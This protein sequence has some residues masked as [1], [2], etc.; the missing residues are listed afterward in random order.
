MVTTPTTYAQRKIYNEIFCFVRFTNN[1]GN[2]AT[3]TKMQILTNSPNGTSTASASVAETVVTAKQWWCSSGRSNRAAFG[4]PAKF[5]YPYSIA[6]AGSENAA[7]GSD[8]RTDLMLMNCR[9]TT[10]ECGGSAMIATIAKIGD[11]GT[12]RTIKNTMTSA[13]KCTWIHQSELGAPTFATE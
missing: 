9:Q 13:M 7:M 12:S 3:P 4:T 11:A 5:I 8:P 1:I 6:T 10:T 2:D